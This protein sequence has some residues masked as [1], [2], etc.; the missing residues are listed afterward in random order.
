MFEWLI[1]DLNFCYC[2]V[3]WTTKVLCALNSRQTNWESSASIIICPVI[4]LYMF[5]VFSVDKA[6]LLVIWNAELRGFLNGSTN[7]DPFASWDPC[8]FC[9]IVRLYHILCKLCIWKKCLD[10]IFYHSILTIHNTINKTYKIW[11]HHNQQL[12][13]LIILYSCISV[14][15]Q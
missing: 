3:L 7:M 12:L 6:R 1:Y 14:Y 13:L 9:L 10:S 4:C 5:A 15:F 2:D 11:C 8:S